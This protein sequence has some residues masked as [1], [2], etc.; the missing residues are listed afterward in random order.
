MVLAHNVS[1]DLWFERQNFYNE[2]ANV[3][4]DSKSSS[5]IQNIDSTK[6]LFELQS[7]TMNL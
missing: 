2:R 3:A 1:T 5:M 7:M 4:V 6:K